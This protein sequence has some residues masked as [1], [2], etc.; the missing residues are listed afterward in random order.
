MKPFSDDGA[1]ITIGG[2]TIENGEPEI[3]FFGQLNITADKVGLD[4]AAKLLEIV[5]SV[6]A[7]LASRAD[8]PDTIETVDADAVTSVKNPFATS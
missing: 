1:S 2:M 5:T 3:A 4:L 6:H 7:V 8:L